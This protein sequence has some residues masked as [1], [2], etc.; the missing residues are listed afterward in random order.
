M[1]VIALIYVSCPEVEIKNNGGYYKLIK[2]GESFVWEKQI[3]YGKQ[4]LFY[5]TNFLLNKTINHDFYIACLC[6]F[7]EADLWKFMPV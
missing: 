6:P 2:C 5:K 4:S 7:E 3:G 1:E